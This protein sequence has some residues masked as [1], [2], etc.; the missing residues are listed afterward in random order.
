MKDKNEKRDYE[1]EYKKLVATV[2]PNMKK[3]MKRY[4]DL[5][6]LGKNN[7]GKYGD[8]GSS[9]CMH[10]QC[11]SCNGTGKKENGGMCVH[12]IHCPCP[13]CTPTYCID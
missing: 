7:Y 8:Q 10:D 9:I 12:H 1:R 5:G 11:P 13:K 4:R 3:Q 6:L 2:S